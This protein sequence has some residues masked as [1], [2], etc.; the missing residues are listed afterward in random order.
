[1]TPLRSRCLYEVECN[2]FTFPY[3]TLIA[4]LGWLIVIVICLVNYQ[5]ERHTSRTRSTRWFKYDRD[6]LCVNKLQ[7]VPV[8]FEPPCIYR[9]HMIVIRYAQIP[10][11]SSSWRPSFFT[12]QFF[13][14]ELVSCSPS[15]VNHFEVAPRYLEN[16]CILGYIVCK[17][18]S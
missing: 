15:G 8:M 13:G 10:G 9:S 11:A 6:W 14:M 2:W 7:F 3:S 5:A 18:R 16:V 17:T 1:M 4:V 12:V